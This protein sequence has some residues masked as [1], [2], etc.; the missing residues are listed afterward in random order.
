MFKD[1]VFWDDY[2]ANETAMS[3]RYRIFSAVFTVC[4]LLLLNS[5]VSWADNDPWRVKSVVFKGFDNISPSSASEVMETKAPGGLGFRQ[6]EVFDPLAVDRD[7][8]RLLELYQ[9]YG[10]FQVK[11]TTKVEKDPATRKVTVTF[12]SH[13][14]QPAR[15]RN[16]RLEFPNEEQAKIW[17]EKLLAKAVIKKGKRFVLDNYRK[18]KDELSSVMSD[19]A[20]PMNK[21]KG[22]VLVQPDRLHAD[23]IFRITPGPKVYFGPT[24]VTG[25]QNVREGIIKRLLAYEEG[26]P[27]SLSL[28]RK[29]QSR[30]LDTGFFNSVS[31]KPRYR[32][33]KGEKA[34]IWLEV[35]ERKPHSFRFGLGW[36]TEESVRVRLSQMNRDPFDL[37]DTLSLEAK[38]S[39]LYE[40]AVARWKVP[41]ISGWNYHFGLSGGVEQ[42]DDEAF[43]HRRY[44]ISPV[45]EYKPSERYSFFLGYNAE[46]D[47]MLDL[48]AAVP[49]PVYEDQAFYIA[50]IPLGVKY[51]ARDSVLNPTKGFLL[52]LEVET[53]LKALNSDLGFVRPLAEFSYIH[54]L[55]RPKRWSLATRIQAGAVFSLLDDERIPLVRRFFPGGANSVRGFPYQSLGP[56]DSAGKPLG[57]EVM[58]VSNW[59]VRFP[60]YKELGGVLFVDAGNAWENVDTGIGSLRFTAGFG[61]RYETPVGP[62]RMDVGYQ[63]NPPE[64]S[65]IS[66]YQFYLS[67]GQAF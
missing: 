55:K 64:D 66:R 50:S 57:G 31:L 9:E 36:G 43:N 21:V 46:I 60:V 58:F 12:E 3:L 24:R 53:A 29:S 44:F 62:L 18:S 19:E 32:K 14:N 56:L 11:L 1:T 16:I 34:P 33:M 27:F 2:F 52:R 48:K 8:D 37:G 17:R 54:P 38:I 10:F 20:H 42:K 67:V 61:L 45:L 6:G 47:R 25:N 51:D 7:K 59:E 13:E 41:H 4:F 30:L 22:Q 49:D 35:H 65:P 26:E 15:I 5:P 39:S 63:L 28:L 23:I 40:G